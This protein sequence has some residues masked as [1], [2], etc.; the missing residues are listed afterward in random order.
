MNVFLIG[1][2]GTGKSTVSRLVAERWGR[3]WVDADEWLERKAG[4]TIREIFASDGETAFRDLET[5]VVVELAARDETV[6]ALGGGAILRETNRTAIRGRG[7]VVWLQ[8]SA[9]VL[10]SRLQ[11]DPSTGERRPALTSLSGLA[12]IEQLLAVREPLYRLC[13]DLVID[14]EDREPADV[15]DEIYTEIRRR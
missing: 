10:A 13:A 5:E 6:I 8:A 11:H 15:A 1:Y 12:E 4:R 14:T 7:L 2:R 3:A 9:P